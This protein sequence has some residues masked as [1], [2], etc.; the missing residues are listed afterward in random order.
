MKTKKLNS[1]DLINLGIFNAIAIVVYLVV[2]TI[3]CTT[4]IGLLISTAVAYVFMG[5]IYMLMAVKIRKKGV[6]LISGILLMIVSL[7]SGRVYHAIGSA[8]GGLLAEYFAGKHDY[9][10]LNDITL[11]YISLTFFDFVGTYL[12]A[13]IMG[14]NYFLEAGAKYGMSAEAISQFMAYFTLPTLIIL[15]V[16]NIA[17]AYLGARIGIKILNKH[18]KKAGLIE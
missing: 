18:F 12:P 7:A 2:A 1:R 9:Q 6:F 10:K 16:L 3:T 17:G 8:I 11:A 13:F 14:K 4:I 5:T 15:V